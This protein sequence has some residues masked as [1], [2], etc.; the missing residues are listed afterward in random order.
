MYTIVL[1]MALAASVN[2]FAPITPQKMNVDI[3][4]FPAWYQ[5]PLVLHSGKYRGLGKLTFS[6]HPNNTNQ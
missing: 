3:N 5:L 1:G 6:V 2:A 4:Y